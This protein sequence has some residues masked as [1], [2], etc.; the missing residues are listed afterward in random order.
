MAK[1]QRKDPWNKKVNDYN[2]Y[3]DNY[4][5][6][7]YQEGGPNLTTGRKGRSARQTTSGKSNKQVTK[8][9]G[10]GSTIFLTFLVAI[11][12]AI[13]GGAIIF[14]IWNNRNSNMKTVASNFYQ[15]STSSTNA[16]SSAITSVSSSTAASS[17]AVA[18]T[19]TVQAG[20]YPYKI[21]TDHGLTLDELY[22]LNPKLDPNNAGYYTDGSQIQ[23]GDVLTISK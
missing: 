8:K 18:K 6:K 14:T 20:D 15:T 7:N 17:A 12:F 5:N 10:V 3:E 23:A 11:M 19:Y 16:S 1:N 13:I 22:K 21:A 9:S 4:D 2:N